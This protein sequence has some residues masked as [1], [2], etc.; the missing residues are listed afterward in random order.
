MLRSL[1]MTAM[2]A[3]AA[4]PAAA[5][6]NTF[7]GYATDP[8]SGAL[9]YREIHVERTTAGAD[10]LETTYVDAGGE[11]IARREVDFGSDPLAPEFRFEDV[12]SGRVV[13]MVRVGDAIEAFRRSGPQEAEERRRLEAPRE[14]VADAGFDRFVSTAWDRLTAGETVAAEFLAASRFTTFRCTMRLVGE[15]TLDGEPSVTFRM[16]ASNPLIRLL[17]PEVDVTYHRETRRLL[18]YEGPSNIRDADGRPMIVRIDFP[19]EDGLEVDGLGDGDRSRAS[20]G[21]H[22]EAGDSLGASPGPLDREI[23]VREGE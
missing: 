11:V 16:G 13:G 9:R 17:A 15:G 2:L 8:A 10:L 14:L 20:S 18:R 23:G 1:A 21:P 3:G 19:R 6:T 7:V 22:V 5:T 12:R 4:L